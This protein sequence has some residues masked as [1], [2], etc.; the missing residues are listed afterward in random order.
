M[1]NIGYLQLVN[2][3]ILDGHKFGYWD[4]NFILGEVVFQTSMVGYV[5]SLTDPSY[6]GQILVSSY[7]LIGNYGVPEDILDNNNISCVFESN[8]IHIRGFIVGSYD[9]IYSHYDAKYSLHDWLYSNKIAGLCNLD[10]RQLIKIIREYGTLSG[11]L[12]NKPVS[13]IPKLELTNLVQQVSCKEVRTINQYGTPRILVIDCG[14]KNNQLRILSKSGARLDIIPWNYDFNNTNLVFDRLFISNG[15]GDPQ[16]CDKLITNLSKFLIKDCGRTPIFGICLGHQILA[17]ALGVKTT[18]MLYGNRGINIPCQLENTN[19][20]FITSQNHG[21]CVDASNLP[22][23][24]CPLFTNLNDNTNE[25]ICHKFYPWFSVQFHPEAKAGPEDT[26]FLFDIFLEGK[27]VLENNLFKTQVTRPTLIKKYKKILILGSGGLKIGQSGE[28]DYSGSQAIKAYKEEGINIVLINPNIATVQTSPEFVDKVYFLPI[29]LE[30]VSRIIKLERPDCISLAFG[31]QTALNCGIELSKTGILAKYSVEVAGTSITSIILAED[32]KLFKTHIESINYEVIPCAIVTQIEEA[33]KFANSN[34]YPILVRSAF[35]LGGLGSGFAHT[36]QELTDLLKIAFIGSK[37]IILDNDLSGW[38]ELEF[39]L[40]RDCYDNCIVACAMENIDPLGI[41]TGESIVVAPC[42]TLSNDDFNMLRTCAI[43]IVRSLG[44]IGECNIQ[45]ALDPNSKKFYIIELNPRL[46]RS[47]ALASKATGYPLAYVG[48]KLGLGYSLIEVK[49]SITRNTAFF[50]PSLD[51][52]VIKV[53]RWDLK[54]FPR[55]DRIIGTSMKSV[56]EAMAIG[57]NFA[58][59][60]QKALRMSLES[61]DGFEPNLVT[62]SREVMQKPHDDRIF[63]IATG[64]YDNISCE[65]IAKLTGIDIW[66]LRQFEVIIKHMRILESIEL[67]HVNLIRAKRL[68][69]SD[70]LIAKFTKS[71]EL[72]VRN[73]RLK[74]DIKP[75]I[76]QIDTVAGEFPCFTNYLYL[77]Y[78]G[79]EHDIINDKSNSIFVLGSGV[80][81]IGSSVEFDC[82]AVSCLRELKKLGESTI[83]I[84]CNPETVSTDYDEAD[85]LYF[86]E[87]SFESV[88]DIYNFEDP[89][90]IILSM[91]G[92]LPNN[93]AMPL[94]RQ[95]V[96]VLGTSPE[97]I[98]K[99]ENRYKFSRLLDTIGV[100][101]PVWK[102]LTSIEEA[103]NFCAQVQY[104][105]LVRPSYVLSGMA[106]NVA[107]SD[108]DLVKYLGTAVAVSRDHP[109]VISKF[110]LDA[111]EIEVDAVADRGIVRYL[112][113]SEHVENAG[114]HSGDA[115]L[116][117]PPNDLTQETTKTIKN[118]VGKIAKYLSITGPF[119]IQFI[120]KENQVK[121]IECNLR[122]SRSFPFV[123]KTL[124]V[125]Y[126]REATKI[127][128]GLE[129]EL[130]SERR[131]I[132]CVKVPQFS[133]SRL[134]GADINLGVEMRSTGEVAC[135]GTNHQEAFIK[136]VQAAG[137]VLPTKTILLSI[138]SY[139]FKQELKQHVR[140]LIKLG[141]VLVGTQGTAEYYAEHDINIQELTQAQILVQLES[142]LIELVII[143]SKKNKIVV[144]SDDISTGYILRRKAVEFNIGVITDVKYAKLFMSSL[145]KVHVREDD[146]FIQKWML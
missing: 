14:L 39:E 111:K 33:I 122:V 116:I 118:I 124:G 73:L 38:K 84:N 69:F 41:H 43:H 75:F 28:F 121:V 103:I 87:L 115:T 95:G 145:E 135:F 98:D 117:L 99:A 56:G 15:P 4:D 46:S 59:A 12:C 90:G 9:G 109:V 143:I 25:G 45:F 48:A 91:G 60:F 140:N 97:M 125:N 16:L 21:Y 133:F 24:W 136:A 58:E 110:I 68:G 36:E 40:V 146:G 120:A 62:Y 106:M 7:P 11:I 108:K 44:I 114:V 31:G 131:D 35:S 107:H 104:P 20:A 93:I 144:N 17:L 138:G 130:L 52:C 86:E 119:N 85:K 72:I 139:K 76:K 29:N 80:Y 50:E 18:K 128:L 54:K 112:A 100:D 42:Q 129:P 78:C 71:T 94:Y 27:N 8:K 34:K 137:L 2:G 13:Q 77:T 113:I 67:N 126:I 64:L 32:R 30:Y 141:Y 123:S 51:Y 19:R 55:A 23:D 65:E 57:R 66:F 53:P 105:C 1:D 79:S 81:K 22:L 10:T 6:T 132:I 88:L 49:N 96:R 63:S 5:E 83:M 61:C 127:I 47:S 134:S 142:R 74:Y 89:R 101:Q 37:Q 3:I 82:C 92:Q 26:S 102:E 70:K